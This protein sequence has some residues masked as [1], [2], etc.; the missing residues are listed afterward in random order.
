MLLGFIRYSIFSPALPDKELVLLQW[1]NIFFSFLQALYYVIIAAGL[2]TVDTQ[3]LVATSTFTRPVSTL[4]QSQTTEKQQVLV[5]RITILIIAVMS[6]AIAWNKSTSV[7]GL[8]A[9]AWAAWQ[10]FWPN[11]LSKSLY[12]SRATQKVLFMACSPGLI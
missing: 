1:F 2:T 9:Y 10:F 11:T 8:V 7:Y 3:I 4:F 12:F 6:Y 5:S